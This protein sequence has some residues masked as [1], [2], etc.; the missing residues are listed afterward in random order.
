[1]RKFLTA[2]PDD[3][4]MKI[5]RDYGFHT[6]ARREQIVALCYYFAVYGLRVND[7]KSRYQL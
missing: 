6:Y 2:L 3:V 5:A 1:M 7:V 4:R